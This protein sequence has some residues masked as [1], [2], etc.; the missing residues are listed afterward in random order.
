MMGQKFYKKGGEKYMNNWDKSG[1]YKAYVQTKPNEK[2]PR[3]GYTKPENQFSLQALQSKDGFLG[4]LDEDVIMLDADSP[5]YS[6]AL[7]KIIQG[8]QLHCM[9]TSRKGGRGIHALFYDKEGLIEKTPTAAMFPC[10]VVLD[11]K[12][13]NKNGLDC[14][15]FDSVE[16]EIIYDNPPYQNIPKYLGKPIKPFVDFINMKEGDG[17]NQSLFNYILTLQAEDFGIEEARETIRI[18]NKYVL[19]NPLTEKELDVILRDDA[20]KKPTFFKGSTFLHDKFA[21]YLKSNY[22]IKKINGQLHIY[23]N[24]T[25][26][27]GRLFIEKAIVKEIPFLTDA[28]RKETLK[29]LDIICDS[30]PL[31]GFNYIAFKNGVYNL[32]DKSFTELNPNIV[33]TNMIPWDYNPAAESELMDST[34]DKIACHDSNIR[35]LLEE[36]IGSCLYRSNTLGGGKAFI[37]TGEGANGKSTFIY[38]IQKVLGEENISALDVKEVN[39]RFKNAE[40]FGKLA[41]IGDDISTDYIPDVGVLKKLITGER[42]GGIERKGQDP[43]EFNNYS[44]FIF[45]AND[46]PRMGGAKDSKPL[47]RRFIIIPFNA[48]FSPE[49][50]D[51]NSN[52]KYELVMQEHIEYAIL[53]GLKG[54]QRVLK[55]GNYSKS[56]K[57]DEQLE[58]FEVRNNSVKAFVVECEENE[59]EGNY[60]I[61]NEP[62]SKVYR[63]YEEFCLRNGLKNAFSRNEFGKQLQRILPITT[64]S[65]RLKEEGGKVCK[66]YV[67]NVTAS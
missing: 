11:G 31:S 37:L 19:K 23:Q 63:H 20:F 43:F 29:Q 7:F 41:N 44:K 65:S 67:Q 18:I 13:G 25:Y 24:G 36:C 50:A 2:A 58:D 22:H 16:R 40:L 35:N 33:V 45:S 66:I 60:N 57:V 55:T 59:F 32:N 27:P 10:G 54:L 38:I 61:I 52:I 4:I 21:N 47:R 30:T 56:E 53:L 1:F 62:C 3:T 28:K 9:V 15:K 8:E 64:K 51:H 17:R 26:I 6:E 49:D 39:E 42:I 46:I 34:L 14:L 12:L 48:V 5:E